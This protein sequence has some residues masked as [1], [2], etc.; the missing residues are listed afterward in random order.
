MLTIHGRTRES[1]GHD[2]GPADWDMIRRIK[3]H[4][5]NRVPI[6]ANGGI[7]NIHDFYRCLEVTGADAVMTSG[8]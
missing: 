2:V 6:I 7:E 4:F 5:K 8:P 3:E 1:K